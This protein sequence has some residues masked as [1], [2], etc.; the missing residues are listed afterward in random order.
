MSMPLFKKKPKSKDEPS[1]DDEGAFVHS[2]SLSH[3]ILLTCEHERV[4]V[5][6]CVR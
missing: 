3:T 4:R 1:L 2:L 5:R 6:V